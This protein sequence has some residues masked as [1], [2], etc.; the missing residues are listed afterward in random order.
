MQLDIDLTSLSNAYK[1]LQVEHDNR[2]FSMNDLEEELIFVSNKFQKLQSEYTESIDKLREDYDK[3]LLELTQKMN[4]LLNSNSW[5]ITAPLRECVVQMR[6]IKSRIRETLQRNIIITGK[7]IYHN[8]PIS[9]L[10]KYKLINITYKYFGPIF[11]GSVHYETWL[12]IN[13]KNLFLYK[14]KDIM[15]LPTPA[16]EN[17]NQIYFTITS[18]PLV[19]II[20][21][22]FGKLAIT[23]NCLN[24]IFVNQPRVTFEIIV[25][26]DASCDEEIDKIANVNGVRYIKNEKNLGFLRSCNRAAKLANGKY[27]HFLNND[28][29]VKAEWLDSLIDVFK[30]KSSCGLVG[31][32]LIYPDGRLQEAGGILWR[33]ASAWN[34]G[35]FQDPSAPEYNYLRETDYCSGASLLITSELFHKLNKFDEIF[36]PAYCEDSD[37]AFSVREAGLKVFYQPKSEVIHYEGISHGTDLSGGIKS[38]QVLNQEKFR[39][40]WSK[41]LETNH[42]PNAENVFRARER[43]AGKSII[44]IIDHYVPYPDRDA[45]SK[46][47]FCFI[48]TLLEMGLSIKFWPEN[49]NYDQQ[50]VQRLQSLGVEV[51]YG[52]SFYGRFEEWIKE[53]GDQIDYIFLSRPHIANLFID[54]IKRN[55]NAKILYY[56]HDLHFLRM[57][58]E[59]QNSSKSINFKE[60]E[61]IRK[62]EEAI[63]SRSDVIYYPSIV[64]VKEVKS[65]NESLNVKLICPYFF[66]NKDPDIDVYNYQNRRGLLFV[67]GFGHPPNIAAANWFVKDVFPKIRQEIPDIHL[68]LVGSNPTEEVK[69]LADTSVHIT[70]YVSEERLQ[71]YYN[72]ARLAVVPL[73][74]GGGIKGKVIEAMSFGIPVVTTPIGI[75]GMHDAMDCLVVSQSAEHFASSVID[76]YNNE[77]K[78]VELVRSAYNYINANYTLESIKRVF[79]QDINIT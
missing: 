36:S 46:T 37:L 35:R 73:T 53:I 52:S 14:S 25:I 66:N 47:M 69:S 41:E 62:L 24:S 8:A 2:K 54:S 72:N 29:E 49:L 60:V 50:Y 33:D 19:T 28:T 76:L 17:L 7:F 34:Y 22:T 3:R 68:F 18:N 75:Q 70:G 32:K 11:S 77:R 64:E 56:G 16:E 79:S 10:S 9:L 58:N 67:A 78:C 42:F 12:N 43:S 21:P 61:K 27:L 44:L 48:E 45:G 6:S 63:W 4:D 5:K 23:L 74:F 55:S 38:F 51:Y 59:F 71:Y 65:S 40:K 31:S 57:M 30:L 39:T 26:E 20:I 13:N 15:S 1:K